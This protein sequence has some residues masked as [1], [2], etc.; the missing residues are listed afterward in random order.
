MP[1]TSPIVTSEFLSGSNTDFT[2]GSNPI[3]NPSATDLAQSATFSVTGSLPH[4]ASG[5]VSVLNNGV[6]QPG[7]DDPGNSYFSDAAAAT[8]TAPAQNG[9]YTLTIDLGLRAFISSI[10][11]YSRHN[12][13]GTRAPQDYSLLGSLDGVHFTPITSVSNT[14]AGGGAYGNSITDTTGTIGL[15]RYLEFQIVPPNGSSGSFYSEIDVN[16]KFVPEPS[17]FVLAGLSAV[18]L[19][20]A[21]RRR[22]A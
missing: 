9:D 18:G 16:G 15:Y 6:L 1:R 17:S 13:D 14:F 11:T 4:P 22:K 10:N 2:A 5:T 19:F 3:P 21:V 7:N 12:G 8:M 20:F